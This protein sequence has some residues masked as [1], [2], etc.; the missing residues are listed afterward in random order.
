MKLVIGYDGTACA[1][2]ALDGLALAGLPPGTQAKVVCVADVW[3][4]SLTPP[5]EEALPLPVAKGRAL[6]RQAFQEALRV[7]EQGRDFLAEQFPSWTVECEARADS[8][9][10][11]LIKAAKEWAADLLVVGSHGRSAVGRILLGSVS[12]KVATE[13]PCSVRI[14]RHRPDPARTEL[15]LVLGFDGSPG[16][17]AALDALLARRWPKE[18]AV[19][20]VTVM[21]PRMLSD[22]GSTES[23]LRRWVQAG[24]MEAQAVFR[25]MLDDATARIER[26]GLR[27]SSAL[28]EGD[29]KHRLLEEAER[30]AVDCVF[31]GAR[32]LNFV[33]RFLLGSVS[34][35]IAGRAHATV[36][37]VRPRD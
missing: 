15:R 4:P 36:E 6:A 20:V 35:A 17:C 23:P 31:V 10:W 25:R 37:I 1:R 7:A 22:L 3:L 14:A 19:H 2:E 32:G 24:D 33:E 12:Q 30:A 26:A 28:L 34:A 21:E 16:A 11:G 29:P 13:A 18:T 9:A 8:P 27:V 5:E